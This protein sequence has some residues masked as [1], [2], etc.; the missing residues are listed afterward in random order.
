MVQVGERGFVALAGK[1]TRDDP[2][3]QI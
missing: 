3:D 1:D 2:E